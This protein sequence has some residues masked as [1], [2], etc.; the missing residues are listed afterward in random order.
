MSSEKIALITGGTDGI[1][2]ATAKK[3]LLE[4]WHVVIVGRNAARCE[5][6]VSGLKESTQNNK[7]SA[8][9]S[10]LSLLSETEKASDAFLKTHER[11]DFLFLNANAIV[12][13]RTLTTEGFESNFALGHLSRALMAKKCENILKA[14]DG[15]QIL[16]VVGRNISKLNYDD[17][18]MEKKFSA[19]KALGKW[20]WAQ[21]L[22]AKEFSSRSSVPM[23]IYM[24]GIVKTKILKNEPQ[25]MRLFI[26]LA[27]LLFAVPVQKSAENVF[28]IITDVAQNNR[29]GVHYSKNKLKD[30]PVAD[31]EPDES[32]KLWDVTG[33]LISFDLK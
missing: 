10:N 32:R 8:I 12:Q 29:K 14:T 18:S 26:G 15:S 6:T 23:N 2:K 3:L 27:Y 19:M 31:T 11:L 13:K 30:S 28:G 4:G 20:Q 1:G 16:S 24:P 22:F 21:Q 33:E 7:I 5:A 9:T 25:P 17:L